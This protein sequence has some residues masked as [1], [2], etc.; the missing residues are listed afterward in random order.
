TDSL[1]IVIRDTCEIKQLFLKSRLLKTVYQTTI[2]KFYCKFISE[3]DLQMILCSLDDL[4]T[5]IYTMTDL[6]YTEVQD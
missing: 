2:Y 1:D 3:I 4:Q 6:Y 5:M